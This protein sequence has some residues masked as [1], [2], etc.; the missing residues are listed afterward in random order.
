MSVCLSYNI[1][2]GRAFTLQCSFQ[3]TYYSF[4]NLSNQDTQYSLCIS[5]DM[6]RQGTA[7]FWSNKGTVDKVRMFLDTKLMEGFFDTEYFIQVSC[8]Y[9]TGRPIILIY[10]INWCLGFM[11]WFNQNHFKK[12][13]VISWYDLIRIITTNICNYILP[14]YILY[15]LFYNL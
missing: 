1:L 14:M 6:V 15:N 2:Q 7:L 13:V 10:I 9:D 4:Y 8:D 11:D 3:N 5:N 12:C